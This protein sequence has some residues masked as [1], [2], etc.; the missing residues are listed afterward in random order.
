LADSHVRDRVLVGV[1]QFVYQRIQQGLL[2][3]M[4]ED[5]HNADSLTLQLIQRIT[6][7][8]RDWPF[9]FVGTYRDD[10]MLREVR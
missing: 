3:Y 9:L 7:I 4:I 10:S 5:L 8:A 6:A 2:F 1:T